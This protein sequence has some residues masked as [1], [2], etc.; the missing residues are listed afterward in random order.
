MDSVITPTDTSIVLPNVR[1]F[2]VPDPGYILIEADLEGAD[3]QVVAWE[4]G[5]EDL[6]HAFRAGLKL[7]LKNVRDVYEQAKN[8]TDE[9]IL[10]TNKPKGLYHNCKRRVHGTNYGGGAKKLAMTLRTTVREEEEF[11][12]RWFSLHP[13]I[14][15]WHLRIERFL[16]GLQCWNCETYTDNPQRPCPECGSHIGRTV[17]NKFG[18]RIVYFNRVEG[19]LP[20]LLAWIPQSTVA[21]NCSK[22]GV[23]LEDK[24]PFVE[25]LLHGHD[26]LLFQIPKEEVE[27]IPAI[28]ETLESIVVPYNDPLRI[29]WGVAISNKSWGEVTEL[30]EGTV[31]EIKGLLGGHDIS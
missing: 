17:R 13:G 12:E 30:K 10:A 21:L 7:H 25:L 9:E 23:A 20:Q 14:K 15:E 3:A 19:L 18:Y 1:K 27:Q 22:G 26:S 29:G 8:M 4:A 2:F 11:Q 24:F 31:N 28:Q 16:Y 6:K 5:D